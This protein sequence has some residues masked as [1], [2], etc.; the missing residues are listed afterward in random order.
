M[1]LFKYIKKNTVDNLPTMVII[2]TDGYV[3]SYPDINDTMGIPVLWVI[4]NKYNTPPFGK[5]ARINIKNI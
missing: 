2:L 5:I 3:F 4:N 1:Y